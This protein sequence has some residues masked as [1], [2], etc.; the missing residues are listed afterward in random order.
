ME[1]YRPISILC[2]L[3]KILERHYHQCILAYLTSHDLLYYAQSGFRPHHSCETAITKLVDSWLSNIENGQFNGLM[4][5][6][7]RKAF[8]MINV[9]ILLTKLKCYH[10]DETLIKW[11]TSYLTNRKQVV[12]VKDRVSSV[13]SISH[14][15]PQGSILGPLLFIM[16]VNDLPL[17]CN[18]DLDLYADDSTLDSSGSSITELND[19]LT[20]GMGDIQQWC[21]SNAMVVNAKKTKSMTICTRQKAARTNNINLQ[22]MH[23]TSPFEHVYSPLC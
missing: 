7:F 5:I 13:A 21:L 20:S 4:F 15:V 9:D 8:D 22:V 12:Q 2:S 23:D 14:G 18:Q 6:D 1:N 10:F 17:H 19:K 16:F 11:M 3:S